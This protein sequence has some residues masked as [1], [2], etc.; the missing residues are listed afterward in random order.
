MGT[1]YGENVAL[2][3]LF[4]SASPATVYL[5][6]YSAA[7]TAAGGG[8]E[9]TNLSR[10]AITNNSTNWPSASS[11]AKSNGTDM[12]LGP[13]SGACSE[14]THWGLHAHSSS[15]QLIWWGP[16]TVPRT[17]GAG[18]SLKFAT[19]DIDLDIKGDGE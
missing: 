10:L 19:G 18:D 4:G 11:G 14:A 3:A 7:P 17:C 16:I 1:T 8:T 9:I 2:D 6:A 12:T 15:D 13:A 5:C